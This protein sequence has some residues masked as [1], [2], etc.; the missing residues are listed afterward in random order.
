MVMLN[1]KAFYLIGKVLNPRAGFRKVCRCLQE[2]W[3]QWEEDSVSARCMTPIMPFIYY[4]L[5]PALMHKAKPL[6][7]VQTPTSS[8]LLSLCHK[9]LSCFLS[10]VAIWWVSLSLLFFLPHLCCCMA[11]FVDHWWVWL[12]LW[13]PCLGVCASSFEVF[14]LCILFL[15]IVLINIKNLSK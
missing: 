7:G 3:L 11:G 15:Y 12:L 1:R 13:A 10:L 8:L 5:S 2:T 14:V 6:V 4:F 9:P